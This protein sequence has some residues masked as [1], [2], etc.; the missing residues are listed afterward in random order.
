MV[1]LGLVLLVA[2]STAVA[3]RWAWG[4][5]RRILDL[6][7]QVAARAGE[8]PQPAASVAEAGASP[9]PAEVA[10]VSSIPAAEGPDPVVTGERQR[11]RRSLLGWAQFRV[12]S[13]VALDGTAIVAFRTAEAGRSDRATI[14]RWPLLLT[15]DQTLVLLIG[16]GAPAT[17][18]EALL[19][20]WRRSGAVLGVRATPLA[21]AIELFDSR[22]SA[23]RAV[24]LA[25]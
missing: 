21:D 12:L 9:S 8:E 15:T 2:V 6:F 14:G 18:A 11:G 25:A 5:Q 24:L 20:R 3:V 23:L 17:Q 13:V 4:Y 19:E 7:Q 10:S 22:D 1:P 16:D